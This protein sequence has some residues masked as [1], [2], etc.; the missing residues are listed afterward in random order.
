MSLSGA[1]DSVDYDNQE[2]VW[3]L[4]NNLQETVNNGQK[5]VLAISRCHRYENIQ[6]CA[7]GYI[8]EHLLFF[9]YMNSFLSNVGMHNFNSWK[10][11]LWKTIDPL[12][13]CFENSH[14]KTNV[15]KIEVV[16]FKTFNKKHNCSLTCNKGATLNSK[17]AIKFWGSFIDENLK[18]QE[19]LVHQQRKWLQLPT[20]WSQWNQKLAWKPQ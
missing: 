3:N 11:S 6:R 9:I 18:W 17:T 13:L 4:S 2:S 19:K 1:F 8:L 20:F 7:T 14:L 5:Y 12:K 15:E 16:V 10:L